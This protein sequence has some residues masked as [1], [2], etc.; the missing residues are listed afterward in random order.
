MFYTV[1][2]QSFLL[3][4]YCQELWFIK[5]FYN[6]WIV[7]PLGIHILNMHSIAPNVAKRNVPNDNNAYQWCQPSWETLKLFTLSLE[8]KNLI[9]L[10]C[11]KIDKSWSSDLFELRIKDIAFDSKHKKLMFGDRECLQECLEICLFFILTLNQIDAFLHSSR[12]ATGLSRGLRIVR[13]TSGPTR[14]R[15]P[16]AANILSSSTAQKGSQTHRIGPSMNRHTKTR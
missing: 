14:A 8:F 13:S 11:A 4:L 16:S 5:S 15:S 10:D 12:V 7:I 3:C 2:I 1:V 9:L 6:F